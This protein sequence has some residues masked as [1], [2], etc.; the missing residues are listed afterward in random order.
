M[1]QK[2]AETLVECLAGI[3]EK[4]LWISKSQE[5]IAQALSNIDDT[6]LKVSADTYAVVEFHNPCVQVDLNH[7]PLIKIKKM[8]PDY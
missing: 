1:E 3:N 8:P 5:I 6:G 7:A 4:L 2:T